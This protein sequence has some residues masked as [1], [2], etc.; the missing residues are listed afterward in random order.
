MLPITM[1]IHRLLQRGLRAAIPEAV[2]ER[3][4]PVVIGTMKVLRLPY[5]A[6]SVSKE[7]WE[8]EYAAGT[9]NYLDQVREVARYSVIIGYCAYFKPGGSLFDVGCGTGLLQRRLRVLGYSRYLGIDG[10]ET[11][12]A[13]ALPERDARTEFL[14]ADAEIYAPP[15]SFDVIIFNEIL[16]YLSDPAGIFRRM[17]RALNPEGI[18][19]VSMRQT[20]NSPP[21]WR[22]LDRVARTLDGVIVANQNRPWE[23]KVFQ[24]TV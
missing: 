7:S 3:L 21:I 24:P 14:C 1:A 2:R 8:Q 9:W 20:P 19:V 13:E 22:S 12:I 4:R 10:S 18:V 5:V 11:A 16:Y 15:E 17:A 23:I 6:Y